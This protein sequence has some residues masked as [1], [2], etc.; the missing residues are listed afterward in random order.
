M[1]ACVV[2][3]AHAAKLYKCSNCRVPFCSASCYRVH[4]GSSTCEA[5]VSASVPERPPPP[6]PSRGD[7]VAPVQT[8]LPADEVDAMLKERQ[9]AALA[10]D[11]RLR[12][13]L[14]S[15]ELHKVLRII[16]NSRARLEAL[17][18]A[19]HNIPE[20]KA[21]CDDVLRCIDSA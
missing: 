6:E 11:P 14:K 13:M 5:P 2:C 17:D 18:A 1:P 21:F 3:D 16:D 10:S 15:A 12:N 9:C 7:E 20:F 19:M 4:R 8:A